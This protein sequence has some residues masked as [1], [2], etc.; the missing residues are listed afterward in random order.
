M[1]N[2]SK[3]S[4]IS[5]LVDRFNSV[6]KLTNNLCKPLYTEDYIIQSMPDVSPTKWHLAHTTWF[7]EKFILSSALP[8]Y[9]AFDENYN[10]LFNSYYVQAGERF[11]RARR[12]VISRPTVNDVYEYREYVDRHMN[13]LIEN[14]NL[15]ENIISII[16]I[17]INHEQQHQ[18]LLLTDIKHV[19]S[20]NPLN[21]NYLPCINNPEVT[22]APYNWRSFDEGIYE[23]GHNG[24][25]FC[26]DNEMQRHKVFLR[27][28]QLASRLIT[29]AEYIE[30]IEAGG[31][32][33]PLL[34]LS[35]GWYT[36]VRE[37]WNAPLYWE[38][39]D[40]EWF[41]FS[42]TGLRKVNLSEPVCHISYY[43]ADAF[44]RWAGLRLPTEFE[45]EAAAST[46]EVKGNFVESGKFH[47]V[48]APQQQK[49]LTQI[50]GDVWEWT[51]SAYLPYPG[52]KIA[53]GALGEYNGKF[54]S[55][56]MVLRGGSF[57]TSVTHIRSTYRNFFPPH[58]RWQ[59]SGLRLA[60]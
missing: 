54:M 48:P 4:D 59:F 32:R 55:N 13:L 34:W 36:V 53:E 2:V 8:D 44:A 6:R 31:Y 22:S 41:L 21:P 10:Y 43:E 25:G 29:N 1:N 3:I 35:E 5:L 18:E 40:D 7:F 9:K 50:F 28:F 60:R 56:Q 37:N 46:A 23:I 52:F 30:F 38:K 19:F 15:S 58:A 33:N 12:G 20:C 14:N 24:E 42:L 57:A 47:P 51:Q 45:W 49:A 27:K 11:E 39:K 16:D 26:Y 17:G